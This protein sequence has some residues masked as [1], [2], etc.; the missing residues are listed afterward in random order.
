MTS[1]RPRRWPTWPRSASCT[2][3]RRRS[4]G[5]CPSSSSTRSDQPDR[6]RA[7]NRGHRPATQ[8]R[9]GRSVQQ[10]AAVQPRS[11]PAVG[12]RR[13]QHRRPQPGR[14]R[15]EPPQLALGLRRILDSWADVR[16]AC[17]RRP[18]HNVP[19][20]RL[21]CVLSLVALV[22]GAPRCRHSPPR[23]TPRRIAAGRID[24]LRCT[25][26]LIRCTAAASWMRQ[27]DRSWLR[28]VNINAE[29]DYWRGRSSPRRFHSPRRMP[30][31]W[32]PSGGTAPGC[33]CRGL[34]RAPPGSLRRDLSEPDRG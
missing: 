12:R 8:P 26:P 27:V 17:R 21:I 5:C 7:S 11:Q 29:V 23:H 18:R 3:A 15:A 33:C 16:S 31:A 19:V 10:G 30:M 32:P 24:S 34:G 2:T 14:P 20:K 22:S 4:H 28:G 6:D 1:T 9:H 25:P 13:S